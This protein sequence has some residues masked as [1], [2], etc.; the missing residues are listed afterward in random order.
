MTDPGNPQSRSQKFKTTEIG[1][2]AIEVY[3]Q[4][5]MG[6]DALDN[7]LLFEE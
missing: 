4:N 2:R 6:K 1:L 7:P 3:E 5:R